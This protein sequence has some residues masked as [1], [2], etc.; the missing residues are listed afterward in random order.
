MWK[1]YI[2]IHLSIL[3]QQYYLKIIS[4]YNL[5]ENI[6]I[7]LMKPWLFIKIIFKK[8]KHIQ[9]IINYNLI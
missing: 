8:Y 7:N 1:K 4:Q 9:F 5:Y 3:L 6:L 2:F